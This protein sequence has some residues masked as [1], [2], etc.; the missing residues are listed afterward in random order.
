MKKILQKKQIREFEYMP[1]DSKNRYFFTTD[2]GCSSALISVGF[3]LV[4][5]NKSNIKKVQFIFILEKGIELMADKYW[6][7]KLEVKARTFFDNT[8][9]LKNRIYSE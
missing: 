1:L 2:L 6:A 9:M 4:S 7:N 8:K 5:L 3:K